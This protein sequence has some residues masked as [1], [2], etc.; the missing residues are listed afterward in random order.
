MAGLASPVTNPDTGNIWLDGITWRTKWSSAGPTTTIAYYIAGLTGNETVSLGGS[1]VTSIT[2]HY[3]AELAAIAS[4]MAAIEAVCNVH[5]VEAS[6]QAGA[7]II[8]A[9]VNNTDARGNLGWANPPGTAFSLVL[10]D[11]QSLIAVN[12][13]LYSP[14]H[15]D[16]ALLV[17]GGYDYI[18]YIH[19]LGHA[20]GLAHPHDTGGGSTIFPGV[21]ASSGDYG[22]FDMNQGIFTMMSYNDGWRTGPL[23]GSPS[24]TCGYEAGPMALDIAA[25]QAMYGANISTHAGNDSYLL[26]TADATGIGYSC[27]WDA[28]GDD[29][30]VGGDLGN[31]IDLRA[32]TLQAAPGGGG[33]ISFAANVHGGFTIA[34]DVL[35][36]NA[37]GGAGADS[38]QGNTTANDLQGGGGADTIHGAAGNDLVSGGS[39]N[40]LLWGDGGADRLLGGDG[41]DLLYAGT[42]NDLLT[43]GAGRDVL[44]GG[45]G[46]DRFVFTSVLDST[47]GTIDRIRDFAPGQDVIDLGAIDADVTAAGDQAF[48]L[49]QG[50]TFDT[51]EIRQVVNASG[52]RLYFNT[53]ADARAEMTIF[54]LGATAPLT[55]A[56]FLL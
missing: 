22:N 7:D 56:D 4:A 13:Q 19:E 55:A 20:L 50:G 10:Q 3:G 31:V 48:V 44:I 28:G 18:T 49:D 54:V 53:D 9:R 1:T 15:P 6:S 24:M 11:S 25:L 38:I 47:A 29:T 14:A 39:E 46:A 23:G 42:G 26:P 35:I 32:A 34:R 45:G 5:F 37:I 41:D 40:D 8:W 43:G 36:E 33:W 2:G 51:G 30:I 52:V 27:I 16:P 21:T 17:P 12:Y